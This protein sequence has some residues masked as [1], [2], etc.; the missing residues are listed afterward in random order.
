M[1]MGQETH[2]LY[3]YK[4]LDTTLFIGWKDFPAVTGVLA[5]SPTGGAHSGL[6]PI[7]NVSGYDP[8][9]SGLA[10]QYEV[11]ENPNPD[12]NPVFLSP[13]VAPGQYQVPAN[14]LQGGKTYYWKAFVKD[15]FDGYYGTST[16]RGSAVWSFV[17]NTPAPTPPQATASP[18]DGS[19][20]T[21]L[22]PT[23]TAASVTDV[24]GDPVKYQFTLATGSDAKTGAIISS[25]WLPTP[26]WTV[27]A[28]TL[29]DGGS[30]SWGIQTNDGYNQFSPTW[31]SQLKVNLRVGTT[32]PSPAD[33][34][35]PVTVNLV[36]GNVNLA[37][38]S[39]TV[40]T[41]GG[42]MGLS[43]SYNSLQAPN[44]FR[45]LTGS[46]YNAIPPLSSTPSYDFTGKTPVLVRTD[47]AV[48][49]DWGA[50]SP[51]PAV[52]ADNF[53]ARWTGYIQVP[54]SGN[55]TF[56]FVHD[57]GTRLRINN[58]L[59][60]DKWTDTASTA[61]EMNSTATAMTATPTPITVEYYEGT[62]SSGVQLWVQPPT[63]LPYVVPSDWFTTQVLTLPNGW[64]S[65]TAIAGSAGVYAS[66]RVSEASVSLTDVSG[67]VHTYLKTSTGGYTPP[68]GE[69]GVLSLDATGLVTLTDDTG[70]VYTFTAEGK[71]ASVTSPVDALKK[72][73]PITTFR[74]GTG[75]LDTISDPL[76]ATG[77]NPVGYARQVRFAYAGDTAASVG[78]GALD[79][80][81][82]GDACPIPTGSGYSPTPAGMLCRIV[83]PG[84]V[85]G[86][87]D[88]TQLFYNSNGQ[89]AAILD[90]GGEL[91]SFGY[92]T[93]G[94]L[95]SLRDS[96]AN[97]WLTA[98]PSGSTTLTL[99]E[100]GYDTQGRASTVTLP[101]PDG[102][103][104]AN[105]PQ[106]T[107]TYGS[108]VS[109]V[110][111][112]GFTVP[113]TAPSNGHAITVTYDS[114][115]RQL[116]STSAA[117]LTASKEWNAK[118][119]LLSA[120]DPWGHKSTTIYNAQD[121]PTDSYGPAP[122]ACFDSTTRLPLGSCPIVP[123]HTQ[124]S[125]DQGLHGLNAQYFTNPNLAGS[126][127]T[128]ALGIGSA[129]GSV[130]QDWG[131]A[132]PVTGLPVDNWSVRLTGLI[133]FPAAG[134]YT[135]RTYADDVT[136]VWVD[137]V[138]KVSEPQITGERFSLP[139]SVTVTAGQQA[140]IRIQYSD[141]SGTAKLQLHW[142]PPGGVDEIVPGSALTPDYGLATGSV[143]ADSAPTGIAGVSSTQVPGTTTATTYANPWL[144]AATAST[145]DPGG[146]NLTTQTAYEPLGSGY[147]RRTSK[148]L[149]AAVAAGAS[150]ATAGTTFT[151]YGDA[152]PLGSV[153]CG[154]P[155]TTPQYGFLKQS[156][157]PAPAVG[158]PIV[159]QY[160]YDVLG[161]TVGTKRSG[162]T[163]WTCSTFDAR[164]RTTST[165][166]SAFGSSPARTATSTYAVNGNPLTL[167]VSD[168][169][170]TGS[171]N[172]STITTTLDLLGR[173]VSYT[174]VWGTVTTPSYEPLTGRVTQVSTTTPGGT[175]QVQSFTY[176]L[177]G[178]VEL[179]TDNGT[180]I[181]DPA[182]TN[183]L[184]ASVAYANGTSLSAITR[185][186]A[187]ATTGISW[188]FP[189]QN[190][191][192][193]RVVRSQAGRI[194][195][196]TLTDGAV[197]ADSF[198]SYDAAG[199]LV[200]ATIP[201]HTL[202]YQFAATGG[203]GVSGSAGLNG[204][205]TGYSDTHDGG[206]PTVVSYCYD[207]ADRLTATTTTGAPAGAGVLLATDL[208][209]ATLAYDAHGNVTTLADQ[210][211]SYDV[212]D[213]HMGTTL[214]DG[215]VITYLRDVTGRIVQRTATPPGGPAVITR[216]TFAGGGSAA[217]AVLDAG[218]VLMVRTLGL[219]GGVTVTIP[220]TGA[221][222][223][224]Y[225]NLH[226][227]SIIS[228]DNAGLRAGNCAVYDPF[229]QPI[230]PVTGN[231]GTST[232]NQAIPDTLPGNADYA[233]VGQ[234]MKLTEHQGSVFTI[235][236][237]VRQYIPALGRFLSVDP[238]EG[239]VVNE[240]V[241]PLDPLNT[242]DLTGMAE[243]GGSDWWRPW[244]TGAAI[245]A[246]IAGAIACGATVVCAVIVGA[247]A[248]AA[249]YAAS[250]AGTSRFSWG[251]LGM[252]AA[253][254]GAVAGVGYL[255]AIRPLAMSV[256]KGARVGLGRPFAI[257]KTLRARVAFDSKPHDFPALGRASQ[258]PHWQINIW[259]ASSS[260]SEYKIH[261]PVWKGFR[262]VFF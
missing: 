240:Y 247:A 227:D 237:G 89:L 45:G 9:S 22:T 37:F 81:M 136:G 166:F 161:R 198:Y 152:E 61:A 165:V 56:G 129:D 119:M 217:S 90:P 201:H 160:V 4:S 138:L 103:T 162:D 182:Y 72:A 250:T 79:S 11:S 93:D 135:I 193:D 186:E 55:Y 36:N 15:G 33:A 50:G 29:H 68:T 199:R 73:T 245:V 99:T 111:I 190:A 69:Y 214:T 171:P 130:N 155:A 194:L 126:P 209:A 121:R 39:P 76:S 24:D 95:S 242:F 106:K 32:G 174:D 66:A 18:S 148:L 54:A 40:S 184:L 252:S 132:A 14:A 149:P 195:K 26:N 23:F 59:V 207:T 246:G 108:G 85:E 12:V 248:G 204:N 154:L 92:N 176:S 225:P 35:G 196:D 48:S 249:V 31:V 51:G 167:S 210:T 47:P 216:Y 177:D 172:G 189:S 83:Y 34:A 251:G 17:T 220:A 206:T 185:N 257:T 44:Q 179:V 74:P 147:L 27:P 200:S 224:S 116:T 211:L 215:T 164:G 143:T 151:Y 258:R 146:L 98:N 113:T 87:P 8:A 218:S 140:R 5:P 107:Y 228:T 25:G 168:G 223:W 117:G 120:T 96:L 20:L 226:G 118:D 70:T 144:G 231:I 60:I 256:S 64:S 236:M 42:P 244:L 82:A 86:Q 21:T 80:N 110:D 133:T 230:D 16:V 91:S 115:Y 97:D 181:A 233:W 255:G 158:S 188:A 219:P 109:Y 221:A 169:A 241:Y 67:T 78:L 232:A 19:V 122:A 234:H 157:G 7:F 191:V 94:R 170:V 253:M 125:Y 134:T 101:A 105:R 254:G 100:I 58:T 62:G 261:I 262:R 208:S 49:F 239:G 243:G 124:V 3:T 71:V 38:A 141:I 178:Q 77:S 235:E 57:G 156:T 159:T 104:S 163:T 63:G 203:C 260:G 137:D 150:A 53:L 175:A 139:G 13:W 46:Y 259:R 65:S 142:T 183:G 212:A 114:G 202:T 205:R 28:G 238:V 2:N 10:Y 41:V 102:V 173:T 43:F 213:R 197:A 128:Y 112:A 229:G 75:Q 6:M 145:V 127:T 30:Y 84:H 52:P 1:L 153:I 222:Q 123:A 192:T 88:T 187:G 180:T 131:S